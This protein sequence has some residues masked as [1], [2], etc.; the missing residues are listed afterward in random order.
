M[1]FNHQIPVLNASVLCAIGI[2]LKLIIPV[3]SAALNEVPFGV[4]DT[5]AFKFV[6]PYPIP[7]FR[8]N[9]RLRQDDLPETNNLPVIVD[10][11]NS[12]ILVNAW[13]NS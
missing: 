12:K 1:G 8:L 11:I 7:G 10:F 6:T 2:V 3:T 4:V 5:R 9:I 13:V